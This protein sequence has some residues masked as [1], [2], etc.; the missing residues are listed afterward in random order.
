[1]RLH[2][3]SCEQSRLLTRGWGTT[4]QHKY[5]GPPLPFS[6]SPAVNMEWNSVHLLGPTL[7]LADKNDPFYLLHVNRDPFNCPQMITN[8]GHILLTLVEDAEGQGL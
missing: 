6:P 5:G 1:M 8:M 7:L 3:I 2:P 4:H